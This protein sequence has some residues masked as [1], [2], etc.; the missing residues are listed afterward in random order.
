MI[1][2]I[3]GKP[4]T[5]KSTIAKILAKKLNFKHYS[6][7]DFCRKIAEEK[8]IT[9]LELSEIAEKDR[10]I[11]KELDIRQI[12][13]GK[14]E[15]N[16]VIDSRLGFY[17]IPHSKKIFLDADI[18]TRARR[19]LD[20]K[21]RNEKNKTLEQTKKNIKKRE[22]SEI[23]RYKNYYNI[24]PYELKNYNIVIDTTNETAEEIA[25]KIVSM[26]NEDKKL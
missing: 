5:G 2:T 22:A 19:I 20:D 12:E 25:N 26:L 10:A 11:D 21:Q 17:F 3:G 13:L 6:T 1:I 9:L 8:G 16:F 14:K 23:K 15:D 18:E 7:G 24:N 4:G